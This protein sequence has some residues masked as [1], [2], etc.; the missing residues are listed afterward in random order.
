[1]EDL[2]EVEDKKDDEIIEF[3]PFYSYAAPKYYCVFVLSLSNDFLLKLLKF[4]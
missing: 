1:V 4:V 2:N 3:I